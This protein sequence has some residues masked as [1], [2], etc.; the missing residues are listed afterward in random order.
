MVM[1]IYVLV[2]WGVWPYRLVGVYWHFGS[3]WCH[4]TVHATRKEWT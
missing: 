3:T 1:K 4:Q 2:F